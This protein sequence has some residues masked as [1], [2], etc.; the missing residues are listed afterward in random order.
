MAGRE[1]WRQA[2][3]YPEYDV[4]DRG[5]V[6]SWT[7][8]RPRLMKQRTGGDGYPRVTLQDARGRKRVERTHIMVARAFLGPARG[9]LVRH[10]TKSKK[11]ALSNLEYGSHMDNHKDKYRDGTDQ[12]GEK[13]SQ[14]EL[15]KTHAKQ[16]YKLKGKYTQLEIAEMYGISRQAVSD[17]HRGITWDEVTGAKKKSRKR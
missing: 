9:R 13:N 15:T 4:S 6:R 2:P 1:R 17:I 5:R 10:K 7:T 11:P 16:I 14:A 12:R 8:G 3:G